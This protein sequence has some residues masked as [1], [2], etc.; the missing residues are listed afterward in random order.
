M[1]GIYAALI[2]PKQN[3]KKEAHNGSYFRKT[4]GKRK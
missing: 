3:T 1:G 2:T 4:A